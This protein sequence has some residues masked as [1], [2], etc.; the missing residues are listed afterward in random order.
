MIDTEK[1]QIASPGEEIEEEEKNRGNDQ[2][3]VTEKTQKETKKTQRDMERQR[4]IHA[5]PPPRYRYACMYTD[6]YEHPNNK[7]VGSGKDEKRNRERSTQKQN[8]RIKENQKD[9][10]IKIEKFL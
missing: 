10:N 7:E 4:E 3:S 6:T 2:K 5:P 1:C 8:E 9:K